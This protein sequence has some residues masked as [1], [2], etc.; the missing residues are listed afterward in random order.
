MTFFISK[1]IFN[2]LL[3]PNLNYAEPENIPVSNPLR[4]NERAIAKFPRLIIV[5]YLEA[6]DASTSFCFSINGTEYPS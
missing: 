4:G 6:C 2:N 5:V 3:A 1:I